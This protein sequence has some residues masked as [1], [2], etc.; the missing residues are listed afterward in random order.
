M[1]VV[2]WLLVSSVRKTIKT[3]INKINN[4]A[5]KAGI[6]SPIHAPKPEPIMALAI[7]KP[8]PNRINMP[9]GNFVVALHSINPEPLLDR[10]I[11]TA[12]AAIIAIP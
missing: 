10:V 1:A 7:D 5:F 12:R 9:H 4:A 8:P 11:K 6:E 3:T 2:A